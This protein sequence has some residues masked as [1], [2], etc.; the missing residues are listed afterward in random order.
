MR[1]TEKNKN[2]KY[3]QWHKWFA[4]HPVNIKGT[5]VWLERV[6]RKSVAGGYNGFEW[7]YNLE[8][9]M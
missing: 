1:W 7:E 2:S 5:W 4:W 6:Y 8:G 9:Q 3:M